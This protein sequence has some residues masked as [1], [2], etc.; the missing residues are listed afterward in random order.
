LLDSKLDYSDEFMLTGSDDHSVSF[1]VGQCPFQVSTIAA[2]NADQILQDTL[3][4]FPS[5]TFSG[6]NKVFDV[7]G[8]Q[9]GYQAGKGA[10]YDATFN[11]Q[12]GG[13]GH[14]RIV[15]ITAVR[16][17][18]TVVADGYCDFYPDFSMYELAAGTGYA[19]DF[20]LTNFRWKGQS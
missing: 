16:D 8:A 10:I 3:A 4:N 11:P 7:R 20:P 18:V 1:A 5:A 19:F 17:G 12:Q 14:V 9:I 15:I 2:G 6:K 13:G